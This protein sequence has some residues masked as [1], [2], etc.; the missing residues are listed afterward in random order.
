MFKQLMIFSIEKE[1][2]LR[3]CGHLRKKMN[4]LVGQANGDN[5]K[6]VESSIR[7]KLEEGLE[8]NFIQVVNESYMHNVPKG[9]ETHF[10]VVVVSEKF[11]GQPL[12]KAK[13]PEQ[14]QESS[15]LVEPS[16]ACRGGFGK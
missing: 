14:W 2:Y 13:T 15:K 9:S 3:A 16:P 7:S 11:A 12:I 6:P 10:K 8:P 1:S 5:N 4:S